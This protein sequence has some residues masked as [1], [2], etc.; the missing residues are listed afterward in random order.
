MDTK[1]VQL[2]NREGFGEERYEKVEFQKR[3]YE[4]FKK[5]ID[6]K[7]DDENCLVLDAKDSIENLHRAI[8]DKVVEV[9][10]SKK[11]KSNDFKTLW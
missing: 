4:N 5:L 3:V 9:K 6:L 11:L 8:L 1:L 7:K 10:N 2:E